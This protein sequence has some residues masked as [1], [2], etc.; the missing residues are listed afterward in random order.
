[1][2][3]QRDFPREISQANG[4]P[5]NKSRAATIK[6]IINEFEIAPKAWFIK[7][8]WLNTLCISGALIRIPIMGGT[9]I[10]A[11]KIMITER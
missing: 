11:K 6:P 9:R 4:T 10:I 5:A 1:M 2:L 7:A 8:G 3:S